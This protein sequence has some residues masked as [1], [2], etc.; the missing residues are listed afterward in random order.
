MDD[1]LPREAQSVRLA[2]HA[3][4]VPAGALSPHGIDGFRLVV[5]LGIK[6]NCDLE[7]RRFSDIRESVC[8]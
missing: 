6:G 7:H 1:V 3:S 5:G 2:E 4:L 8:T